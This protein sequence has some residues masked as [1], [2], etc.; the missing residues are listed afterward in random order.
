MPTMYGG[1]KGD[2]GFF[3]YSHFAGMSTYPLYHGIT[4]MAS[5]WFPW[6]PG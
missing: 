2:A 1:Q 4:L 6:W 3:G 5:R